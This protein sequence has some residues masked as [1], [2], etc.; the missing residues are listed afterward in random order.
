M[1]FIREYALSIIA[2]VL[3]SVL[4]EIMM[5]SSNFKKY[6][7]LVV[8]LLVMFVLVKPVVKLPALE[9]TLETFHISTQAFVSQSETVQQQIDQAQQEQISSHFTKSLEQKIHDDIHTSFGISCTVQAVFD[10]ETIQSLVIQTPGQAE[11]IRSFIKGNY[12]LE[13]QVAQGG[14]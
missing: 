5:P 12:G 4:L 10:G 14:T 1:A 13:A 7:K 11:E 3:F 2:V 8:G 6:I 9:Q